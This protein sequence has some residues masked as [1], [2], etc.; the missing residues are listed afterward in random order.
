MVLAGGV[1]SLAAACAPSTQPAQTSPGEPPPTVVQAE[2]TSTPTPGRAATTAPTKAA[3]KDV[4]PIRLGLPTAS[5]QNHTVSWYLLS[6]EKGFQA[7]QGVDIEYVP[8]V[9][10]TDI[11]RGVVS[12]DLHIGI[13]G[14]N[15]IASA[16]SKGTEVKLFGTGSDRLNFVFA[17]RG[18]VRSLADA[19]GKAIG[20]G[21]FGS[22]SHVMVLAA[23]AELGIDASQLEFVSIGSTPEIYR[24]LQAGKIDAGFIPTDAIPDL[25]QDPD[26][27]NIFD[28]NVVIP[29]FINQVFFARNDALT[30]RR[31][32]LASALTAMALGFRYA[33]EHRE[34]AIA[35][36]ARTLSQSPADVEWAIDYAI[37]NQFINPN[38]DF[39]PEQMQATQVWNLEVQLQDREIPIEQFSTTEIF[40]EVHRR[41]GRVSRRSLTG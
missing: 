13:A 23:A 3:P 16:V 29:N 20:T 5:L 38:V 37:Q 15:A 34:E 41:I 9:S 22:L 18:S 1:L 19:Q 11:L 10:S 39:T 40:E 17:G 32:L 6:K 36:S 7:E 35:L 8:I 2:R 28:P 4:T 27:H 25:E 24:A 14:A 12:G 21:G 26:L 30:G 33:Y 31:D